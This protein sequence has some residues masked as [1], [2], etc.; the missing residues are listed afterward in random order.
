MRDPVVPMFRMST[1]VTIKLIAHVNQFFGDNKLNRTRFRPV[2]AT[3]VDQDRMPVRRR[4]EYVRSSDVR[5]DSPAEPLLKFS[6]ISCQQKIVAC[7]PKLWGVVIDMPH[8][9]SLQRGRRAIAGRIRGF[10]SRFP[11]TTQ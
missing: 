7:K 11:P 9:F 5:T 8:D 1:A 10:Q 2:D 3:K 4:Q 6:S